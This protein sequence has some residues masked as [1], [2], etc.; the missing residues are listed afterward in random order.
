MHSTWGSSQ[1]KDR[2]SVSDITARFFTPESK[3]GPCYGSLGAKKAQKMKC[4]R[5]PPTQAMLIEFT[6]KDP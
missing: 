4:C 2:T 5:T 1:P 6:P 3:G